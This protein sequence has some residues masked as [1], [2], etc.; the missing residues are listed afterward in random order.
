MNLQKRNSKIELFFL[1]YSIMKK[2]TVNKPVKPTISIPLELL[3]T[4]LHTSTPEHLAN[5]ITIGHKVITIKDSKGSDGKASA[6]LGQIGE[7]TIRK[8]YEKRFSIENVSKQGRTGDI[9]IRR[10]NADPSRPNRQAILIEIKNYS[11]QVGVSEI[12]KFYRD[13]SANASIGGGIF[14]SLNTKIAGIE[15]SL[16]FAKRG[17]M[18]II[19]LSLD[20][21]TDH[22][23]TIEELV[24]L[25]ADIIWANIDSRF[26]VDAQIFQKLS[27]QLT[28]LNDCINGLSMNRAYITETRQIID[29]QLTKIY[30]TS[31]ET[32]IGMKSIISSITRTLAKGSSEDVNTDNDSKTY[33]YPD[34]YL[35]GFT[36]MAVTHFGESLY[37]TDAD[38]FGLVNLIIETIYQAQNSCKELTLTVHKKGIKFTSSDSKKVRVLNVHLLKSRTDILYSTNKNLVS[39]PSW[40]SCDNGV[41][42]FPLDAN[43]TRRETLDD[44][45]QTIASNL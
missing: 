36:D 30:E 44:I 37:N 14:I 45:K 8:I 4:E 19:F 20:W 10:K 11:S 16:H 42:T 27:S 2:S 9:L 43:S 24:T 3:P 18:P 39:C 7:D 6:I 41:I 33:A 28:K 17:D 35:D 38:H 26:V 15:S 5:L 31:Y 25:T 40:A 23:D 22:S 32:E 29:K 12:E 21:S 1:K 34:Q 13:L